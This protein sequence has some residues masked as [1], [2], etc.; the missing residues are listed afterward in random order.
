MYI[1]IYICMNCTYNMFMHIY[2]YITVLVLENAAFASGHS[3]VTQSFYRFSR[4]RTWNH[5]E[6]SINGGTSKWMV[7]K[8]GNPCL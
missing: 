8:V 5:L 4:H 2:V 6:V 7:K 3:Q 1:Y